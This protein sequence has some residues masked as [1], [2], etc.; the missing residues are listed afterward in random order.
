MIVTEIR[1]RCNCGRNLIGDRDGTGKCPCG[2]TYRI[3]TNRDGTAM[4]VYAPKHPYST[5]HYFEEV[6]E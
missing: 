6:E 1:F 5:W 4:F 2:R 3:S